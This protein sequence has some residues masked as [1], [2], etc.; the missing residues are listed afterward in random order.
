MSMHTSSSITTTFT[1]LA[2]LGAAI[3]CNEAPVHDLGYTSGDLSATSAA[4]GAPLPP[5]ALLASE[6][7]GVWIGTADDPL[8]LANDAETAPPS[9]RFPSG[10]TQIRLEL[11][12]AADGDP[13][14]EGEITFGA[15]PPPPLATDPDVGY[16]DPP[17]PAGRD[18]AD[19]SV[20]PAVEGFRYHL[21]SVVHGRDL[22]ASGP[23]A[24]QRLLQ[25]YVVDG[26]LELE[27]EPAQVF[28][29]WCALQTENTCPSG[30]QLAWDNSDPD[31]CF[32]G[33]DSR[34]MDC[35]KAEQCLS[36][37]CQCESDHCDVSPLVSGLTIR[38]SNDGVVALGDGV[39]SND[40][41]FQQPL[42]TLRFQREVGGR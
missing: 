2:L 27:Y 25:G 41:G 15:A 9:F 3:A 12:A 31:H 32:V 37:I 33:L 14:V 42:G 34:P 20:R 18:S 6:F 5:V 23:E 7:E 4:D 38:F 26:K 13:G 17:R 35:Q 19:G 30:E 28:E 21:S 24:E 1:A 29:S 10:S 39:F 16:L 40:R 22:A 11:V 36:G 8:A